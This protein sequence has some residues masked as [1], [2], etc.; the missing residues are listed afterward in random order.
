MYPLS[1][2]PIK[3]AIEWRP[4]GLMAHDWEPFAENWRNELELTI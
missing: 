1:G 2:L 3:P 4:E